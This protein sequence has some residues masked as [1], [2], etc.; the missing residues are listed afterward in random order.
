MLGAV[1]STDALGTW[2]VNDRLLAGARQ[3]ANVQARTQ[4]AQ[5][6]AVYA[7]RA[8]TLQAEG[9]AVSLYPAVIAA[10][11]GN[12]PAPL[13]Q[14]SGQVAAVQGIDVT[15]VDAAGRVIAR[16]HAPDQAGDDLAASLSGMRLALARQSVSGAEAGDELG[17]AVRGY[18]PVRQNGREGPVVGA[19]MIAEPLGPSLLSRLRPGDGTGTSV[20]ADAGLNGS[21]QQACILLGGTATASCWFTL[22]S[23][24]GQPSGRLALSVPL[25]QID[26]ALADAQHA[27]WAVGA[28]VLLGGAIAAWLL[29]RSLTRPLD[30]LTS[31]ANEIA[32]G[33]YGRAL[34]VSGQDEIGVLGGAFETMRQQVA[35]TTARL[36]DQRDV[37]DAVLE[38]IANG[39]LLVESAGHQVVANRRWT[40]LLG[41]E[42]LDAAAA[43]HRVDSL[44]QQTF[45]EVVH[46]WVDDRVRVVTAEFE[47][48]EPPYQ[49]VRCYTAPVRHAHGSAIGRLFVMRDI[50]HET[51]AERMR[52][53]FVA[54]VS[55]EL[56]SPLTAIAGYT[57]TL[58][59]AG[60]WDAHTQ[61][62]FLEIV[63][64]AVSK[65]AGLV[66][67]L[68]EA[69][70]V[71]AGVLE[72]D[73][74]PV[75]VERLAQQ[76]LTQRRALAPLHQ[77]RVE[78][79]PEVPLAEADPVRVEQVLVNLVDNA[80]KYS[81]DGGPITVHIASARDEL[82]IAVSDH[83]VGVTPEHAERLFERFYRA[84]SSLRR[85][86]KGVGL[87][88]FICRS[89]VEAHG[90]RIWV[91][92]RP[93]QG[94]TFSFTL[95]ALVDPAQYGAT[96]PGTGQ[97][98]R[99]E[100]LGEV[101][102]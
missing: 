93:G 72:L 69:A 54:T 87:G 44:R 55:H 70:K 86:T 66:D 29:A 84:D 16:G 63:A 75:R 80:I 20:T 60:P 57:D 42:G 88:L 52:S 14:W 3:E 38:S 91:E 101:A 99:I 64:Q 85:T 18:A 51:E 56:R 13:L 62:E 12:N 90:G 4:V 2:A 32:D 81:P 94:S 76:V 102:A 23:P 92:S 22:F 97:D 41:G 61:R 26:Q 71:E 33:A 8:A 5:V 25:N 17:L 15:V 46:G 68:L 28:L 58:L 7:E 98:A 79:A 53:A 89:L 30:R 6:H 45:G 11:A 19:V 74:A 49:R 43:L 50:T 77:L 67:N 31:A 47:R 82:R 36:R 9:E 24:D 34:E 59:K 37:L 10:L 65:L 95:P 21:T 48:T 40:D 1:L 73:R 96:G 83:G 39:V 27:L 78:V 35:A 100:E